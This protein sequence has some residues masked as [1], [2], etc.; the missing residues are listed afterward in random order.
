MLWC[1]GLSDALALLMEEM[2]RLLAVAHLPGDGQHRNS[3]DCLL[4]DGP[5]RQWARAA[6]PPQRRDSLF[7]RPE[8]VGSS[9]HPVSRPWSLG[10]RLKR[11]LIWLAAAFG[12]IRGKSVD[13]T[14]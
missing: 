7:W 8:A 1:A 11:A 10:Q 9:L 5:Y 12:P 14:D 3:V 13:A 2:W 6:N 4:V